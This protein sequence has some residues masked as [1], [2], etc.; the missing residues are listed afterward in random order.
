VYGNERPADRI[1]GGKRDLPTFTLRLGLPATG[2]HGIQRYPEFST[3]PVARGTIVI[4][5]APQFEGRT[6]DRAALGLIW[7]LA[8]VAGDRKK[9]LQI[10]GPQ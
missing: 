3:L 4:G 9:S 5:P 2:R 10:N 1:T 6:G 8:G 7:V